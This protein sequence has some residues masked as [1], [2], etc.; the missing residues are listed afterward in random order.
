MWW[1]NDYY[2]WPMPWVFMPL[3]MFLFMASV[4]VM[5]VSWFVVWEVMGRAK[6]QWKCSMKAARVARSAN[7]NIAILGGF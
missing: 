1:W 4:G 2:Y 6:V 5:I 3:M 7:P